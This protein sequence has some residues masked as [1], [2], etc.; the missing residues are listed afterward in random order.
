MSRDPP[1]YR[2]PRDLCVLGP[3]LC[4][5]PG[6]GIQLTEVCPAHKCTFFLL[7][8]ELPLDRVEPSSLSGVG[9]RS[10]T[11]SG[12]GVLRQPSSSNPQHLPG[13]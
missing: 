1:N 7:G 13:S 12:G 2:F 9:E 3:F 8:V 6:S 4:C 10:H 5:G 11:S